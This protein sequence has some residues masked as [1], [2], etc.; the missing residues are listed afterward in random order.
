V[1]VV[2]GQVRLAGELLDAGDSARVE[3]TEVLEGSGE[4]LV[5]RC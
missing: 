4:A 3:G 5:W 2:S 1:L